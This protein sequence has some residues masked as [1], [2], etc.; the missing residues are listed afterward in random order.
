[1]VITDLLLHLCN[2][3]EP[4]TTQECNPIAIC[5]TVDLARL[6]TLH[7]SPPLRFTRLPRWSV[8]CF[9]TFQDDGI[10]HTLSVGKYI[11]IVNFIL[12]VAFI[13]YNTYL[14]KQL[15]A[16]RVQLTVLGWLPTERR[17]NHLSCKDSICSCCLTCHR[18]GQPAGLA[19]ETLWSL[20]IA[21]KVS[22]LLV[23]LPVT[24]GIA[25]C[26]NSKCKYCSL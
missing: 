10:Q 6:W 7:P 1:M 3:R 16:L 4:R 21:K 12:N 13:S 17:K 11:Q 2:H 9:P 22:T 15:E 18:V 8:T 5:L 14:L 19:R 20:Q 26:F 24:N 23:A 25:Q